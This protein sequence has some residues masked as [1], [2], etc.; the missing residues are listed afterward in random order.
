M[1]E[2]IPT[3]VDPRMTT[4]REILIDQLGVDNVEPSSI[5]MTDLG[6]DILDVVEI[7][8]AFEEAFDI[9]V[10]DS[11]LED[12][13]GRH[14]INTVQ[15]ILDYL[16]K[17]LGP[18]EPVDGV[19][20][21]DNNQF[22]DRY[23]PERD[24]ENN[25]YYR[26]RDW[27]VAEDWAAVEA[28]AKENRVWTAQDDDEGRFCITNGVHCVNRLY[29]IITSRPVENTDWQVQVYDEEDAPLFIVCTV[30]WDTDEEKEGLPP[31]E[32]TINAR[33]AG[34]YGDIDE[35]NSSEI[36]DHLSDVYGWCVKSFDY[37]P[38]TQAEID[39][40]EGGDQ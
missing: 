18:A 30:D 22:I 14:R 21:L 3:A 25:S 2:T 9:E 29:Y 34:V 33:N 37:R 39:A 26:Q 10:P 38:A 20:T 24:T 1:E 13:A 15:N 6:A 19:L 31:K 4:V 32:V 11:D 8:M 16:N 40:L 36:A 17:R 23:K 35:H 12:D 28:A 27:T 7:L 5:L